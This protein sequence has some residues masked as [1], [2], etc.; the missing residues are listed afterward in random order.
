[1]AMQP[2]AEY[3]IQQKFQLLVL[4]AIQP[5]HGNDQAYFCMVLY[6]NDEAESHPK[7]KHISS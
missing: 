7:Q 5:R 4:D 2:A 1:M 6:H 3:Q